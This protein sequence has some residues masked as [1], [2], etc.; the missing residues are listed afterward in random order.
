MYV[1]EPES[2]SLHV[3]KPS[4]TGVTSSNHLS[5]L[6]SPKY[7]VA[8]RRW[9]ISASA[10]WSMSSARRRS[11][12]ETWRFS[13]KDQRSYGRAPEPRAATRAAMVS[14]ETGVTRETRALGP[15]KARAASVDLA[16]LRGGPCVEAQAMGSMILPASWLGLSGNLSSWSAFDGPSGGFCSPPGTWLE[17]FEV[18]AWMVDTG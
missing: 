1:S 2:L 6:S 17:S 5:R 11:V 7:A 18:I 10:S 4:K 14:A 9:A 3:T 12:C 15:G 16:A 13:A 8:H